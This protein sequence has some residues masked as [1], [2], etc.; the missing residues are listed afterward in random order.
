MQPHSQKTFLTT[1]AERYTGELTGSPAQGYLEARGISLEAALTA[2][3]GFVNNP[4]PG[5]EMYQGMLCIPYWTVSGVAAVKF[6]LVDDRP[7]PRYLWPT[8]QRSHMYNTSAVLSGKDYVVITEGE[9]DTISAHYVAGVNA[10]G[11]AGV[12]HWKPHHARVLKGFPK[13]FVLTDNDDKEN[14]DNPGQDL[15]ARIIRDIPWARNVLL[16]RGSDVNDYLLQSGHNALAPLLGIV[17]DE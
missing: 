4:E 17:A 9:L 8:G 2:R 3:L 6:R 16:P 1:A 14:G 7:G 5:H 15:A 13:I 12:N 10:V 11:I